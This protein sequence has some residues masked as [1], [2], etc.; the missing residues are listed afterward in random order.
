MPADALQALQVLTQRLGRSPSLEELYRYVGIAPSGTPQPEHPPGPVQAQ[1]EMG[2]GRLTLAL[3][4]QELMRMNPQL[5]V[6][7]DELMRRLLFGMPEE[8]GNLFGRSYGGPSGQPPRNGDSS[9][10]NVTA[11]GFFFGRGTA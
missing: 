10:L 5:R 8:P 6:M 2:D 7:R 11:P 9:G 4:G 3:Q 1:D